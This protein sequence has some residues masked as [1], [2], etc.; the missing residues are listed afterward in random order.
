MNL[1]RTEMRRA[2]HRR[3]IR[4]LLAL[5]LI[6]CLF[7]GVVAFFTART[8]TI[9]EMRLEEGGHPAIVTD[10]WDTGRNDGYLAV[11]MMFL[12]LG[13]LFGGATYAGAEWRTGTITTV[14]TWEPR[15]LRLHAARSLAAAL[16][17]FV[18]ATAVQVVFLLSFVP[19]VLTSGTAA[20]TDAPFWLD[21]AVA[22]VRTSALATAAVLIAIAL[23][24]VARN[25][26]FAV[27][28]VSAWVLVVE[29]MVRGLVPSVSRWLWAE[30]VGTVMIWGQLS[31]VDFDRGPA[32]AAATLAV[33]V[34]LT[35][36]A[37]TLSFTRR[38]I[39]GT[40]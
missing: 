5:A 10:W 24:T 1:L 13:G 36:V 39:A 34:A 17:A 2:L 4:V 8:M 15:R 11:A 18:I 23:A 12:V 27:I 33:Y 25:T 3:A 9:A 28:A 35:V 40:T 37:G 32:S 26:A 21:L 38:D 29:N 19:A 31:D 22:V 20:G 7:A 16:L 14:L 6:G 30:N